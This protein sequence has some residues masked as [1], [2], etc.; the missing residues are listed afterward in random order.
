M[1]RV[2]LHIGLNH[3]DE[4]A[5]GRQQ[6]L[7]GAEN[8]ARAMAQVA[9]SR[10]FT[11]T[12]LITQQ[13]RLQTVW[14]QLL[15]VS[16]QLESGDYFFLTYSGHGGRV[17]DK[18][19]GEEDDKYDETWCLYDGQLLDDKLY[20]AICQFK[21]GVRVF[22]LSD[23]CHSGTVIRGAVALATQPHLP[24][25]PDAAGFAVKTL[26][27][28]ITEKEYAEHGAAYAKLVIPGQK[29]HP[30]ADAKVIL[31]SGCR[32][33]QESRDGDPNGVFTTAFLSIW[34][35]GS[36]NRNFNHL[37]RQLQQQLQQSTQTPD[38][39]AYGTGVEDMAL[40]IPL[41]D[42]SAPFN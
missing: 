3:L 8:D 27:T 31:L 40:Q 4:A 16:E 30:P 41:S 35:N 6:D 1:T 33:D 24:A 15:R 42:T 28:R 2:S 39:F 19:T 21:T 38:M 20:E 10:G 9:A 17:L 13:A 12:M 36:Y 11:P 29:P 32:D 7:G 14:N 18:D 37:I 26:P 23:S 5:W 22:V 25:E 34:N